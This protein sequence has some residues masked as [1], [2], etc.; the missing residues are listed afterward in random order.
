M[1]YLKGKLLISLSKNNVEMV[2]EMVQI[3]ESY[4]SR[5]VH[6]IRELKK[7]NNKLKGD[8]FECFCYLYMTKIYKLKEVWFY[9]DIPANIKKKLDLTK[10]DM[11]ID[12]IGI[13]ENNKYYAIQAKYRKRNKNKKTTITWKQLST[14]Y[15]LA[16]KTGPYVKHIVFTNADSIRHIGKKTSKDQTINY[17]KIKKMNHFDWIELIDFNKDISNKTTKLTNEELRLKRIQYYTN[18]EDK[19]TTNII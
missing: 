15:A 19:N 6:N 4:Y 10:N 3:C 16:L 8:I 11:G 2:D 12:F 7:R 13:D 18:L 5:P 17:N 14:F 9:S 1:E